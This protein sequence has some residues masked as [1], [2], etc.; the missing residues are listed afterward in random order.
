ME[1]IQLGLLVLVCLSFSYTAEPDF[2]TNTSITPTLTCWGPWI[3][4]Y[5]RTNEQVFNTEF[6][7]CVKG[8]AIDDDLTEPISADTL[9][10]LLL[11]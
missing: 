1:K 6:K 9:R 11:N 2:R 5:S 8:A 7:K 10:D 3:G 4:P